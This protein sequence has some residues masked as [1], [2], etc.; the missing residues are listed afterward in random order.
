LIFNKRLSNDSVLRSFAIQRDNIL[1]DGNYL[2][3]KAKTLLQLAVAQSVRFLFAA[4]SC[5]M[6]QARPINLKTYGRA[7]V[8][9]LMMI[10]WSLVTVSGF[11]LCS[12][13]WRLSRIA[14]K[15]TNYA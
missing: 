14:N 1:I 6:N 8:A 12:D 15:E 9:I 5:L 13:R 10:T 7:L 11:V 2:G 3:K 4:G